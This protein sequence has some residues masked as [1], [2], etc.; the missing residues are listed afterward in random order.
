MAKMTGVELLRSLRAEADRFAALGTDLRD[1]T[2][3]EAEVEADHFRAEADAAEQMS[4]ELTG[5]QTRA[6]AAETDRD[7]AVAKVQANAEARIAAAGTERAAAI[8]QT[9]SDADARVRAAEVGRTQ[10]FKEAVD[11]EAT[12]RQAWQETARRG[13]RARLS[14]R[15]RAGAGRR[16][17]DARPGPSRGRPCARGLRADL[18]TRAERAEQQADAFRD[19]LARLAQTLSSL[20]SSPR[21]AARA[22]WPSSPERRGSGDRMSP[23]VSAVCLLRRDAPAFPGVPGPPILPSSASA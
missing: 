19:E 7:T 3:A 17:P 8:A 5:A 11:A 12:V 22:A 16:R 15:N 20:P 6:S 13:R 23:A 4:G 14:G 1:P 2:A 21:G 10:A 9:R 18:R